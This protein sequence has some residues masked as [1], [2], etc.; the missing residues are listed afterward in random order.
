MQA[1]EHDRPDTIGTSPLVKAPTVV[2]T[3]AT[4]VFI[5]GQFA[6]FSRVTI[7]GS[8]V[9][10]AELTR[11][12]AG[13]HDIPELADAHVT[14][15]MHYGPSAWRQVYTPARGVL[16]AWTW[17]RNED[18]DI[19][20]HHHLV[21][22]NTTETESHD[23]AAAWLRRYAIAEAQLATIADLAFTQRVTVSD[24]GTIALKFFFHL[25]PSSRSRSPVTAR[26]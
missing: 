25:P 16:T 5:D 9:L 24:P 6:S 15:T 19:E 8:G 22:A 18:G 26:M 23:H 21:A 17:R 10:V 20:Q 14:D 11:T 2:L 4:V 3:D 7:L 13:F 1:S 12:V